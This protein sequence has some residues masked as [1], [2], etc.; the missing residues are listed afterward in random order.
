MRLFLESVQDLRLGGRLLSLLAFKTEFSIIALIGTILLIATVK[1]NAIILV[2]FAIVLRTRCTA[3][4]M[5]LAYSERAHRN[6]VYGS[7]LMGGL[8]A[9]SVARI[10]L[11]G[12]VKSPPRITRGVCPESMQLLQVPMDW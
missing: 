11:N 9:R 5:R 3:G 7:A 4:R 12:L 10:S 2:D 8:E 1:K 6:P